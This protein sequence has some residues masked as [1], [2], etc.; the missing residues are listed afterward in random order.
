MSYPRNM[1]KPEPLLPGPCEFQKYESPL[2]N[3]RPSTIFSKHLTPND[4]WTKSF[5]DA[6]G[7]GHYDLTED[8]NQKHTP[9]YQYHNSKSQLSNERYLF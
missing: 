6:P 5:S 1:K 2:Y 3:T 4:E 7:P 8:P 9:G